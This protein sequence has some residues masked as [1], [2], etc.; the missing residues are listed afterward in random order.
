MMLPLVIPNGTLSKAVKVAIDKHEGFIGFFMTRQP[1]DNGDHYQ[2][3]DLHTTGSVARIV[4]AEQSG[5]AGM[6][7]LVHILA[8]FRASGLIKEKPFVQIRGEG[9]RPKNR[10]ARP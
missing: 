7:V 4:K 5:D 3:S 2:F 6:Q 8:R 1:L 10:C 9:V